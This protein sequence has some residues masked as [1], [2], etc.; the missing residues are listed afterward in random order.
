MHQYKLG[1]DLLERSSMSFLYYDTQNN[2]TQDEAAEHRL[3]QDNPF[4]RLA[5]NA[6]FDVP[7][8]MIGLPGCLG[9]WLTH[10]QIA[11]NQDLQIL[12]SMAALQH[13]IH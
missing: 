2:S 6:M 12:F 9:T 3:Q 13:L 8:D 4:P 10:V 1:G 5:S 11:V 7:Q